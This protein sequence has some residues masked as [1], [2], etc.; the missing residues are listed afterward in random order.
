MSLAWKISV[1]LAEEASHQTSD[2]GSTT[3]PHLPNSVRNQSQ[4]LPIAYLYKFQPNPGHKAYRIKV[5]NKD[6]YF[7][8]CVTFCTFVCPLLLAQCSVSQLAYMYYKHPRLTSS[9]L[10]RTTVYFQIR[11]EQNKTIGTDHA[12]HFAA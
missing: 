6:A 2:A 10:K 1:K 12:L 8:C 7:T 9:V 4:A 5:K 3:T 11:T